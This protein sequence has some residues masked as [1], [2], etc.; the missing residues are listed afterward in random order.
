LRAKIKNKNTIFFDSRDSSGSG[1]KS[2]SI[3]KKLVPYFNKFAPI[4]GY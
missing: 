1:H 4:N 2:M 3:K